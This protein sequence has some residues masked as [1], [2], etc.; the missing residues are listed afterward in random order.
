[1]I[2]LTPKNIQQL[3]EQQVRELT[4]RTV[5]SKEESFDFQFSGRWLQ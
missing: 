4:L 2:D 3:F 1:M 5:I